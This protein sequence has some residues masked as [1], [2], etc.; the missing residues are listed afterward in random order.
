MIRVLLMILGM[1][2]GYANIPIIYVAIA[3]YYIFGRYVMFYKRSM[4]GKDISNFSSK[5]VYIDYALLLSPIIIYFLHPDTDKDILIFAW[6]YF[7]G[8]LST[9][10][11]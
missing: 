2:L 7:T 5:I 4:I 8:W 6:K 10:F 1:S 11:H 9:F 3:S